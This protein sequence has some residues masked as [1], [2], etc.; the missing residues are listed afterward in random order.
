MDI[1]TERTILKITLGI[2]ITFIL[3]TT[4]LVVA[5]IVTKNDNEKTN[6]VQ[7]TITKQQAVAIASQVAKGKFSELETKNIDGILIYS[8]EFNDGKTEYDIDVDAQTGNIIKFEKEDDLGRR[9]LDLISP[10]V[11]ENQAK[12]I[13]LNAVPGK[14]TEIESSKLNN[15]YV[16]E[17]E[18][19]KGD[20]EYDVI[21]DM[22][23]GNILRIEKDRVEDDDDDKE[24]SESDDL[25]EDEH[26]VDDYF[27]DEREGPDVPITG[28]A[29]D[30]ASAAALEYLGEGR[31]T[32]TEV[33]DE[34]GYYEIEVRLD[35]GREVDVHLDENFNVLSVED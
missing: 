16:Y 10:N 17:V 13:A 31:V 4:S 6:N 7:T 12:E 22:M 11:N 27:E 28:N 14:A 1:K 5:A 8:I 9:E 21:I 15:N 29:L 2:L 30:R 19:Q 20:Y 26:E 23:S 34:E 35:S 18:V 32:D 3:V 33:G 25:D 24:E